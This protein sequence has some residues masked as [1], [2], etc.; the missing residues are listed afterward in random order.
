MVPDKK[1]TLLIK[2]VRKDTG[3]A[4]K[5]NKIKKKKKK[6]PRKPLDFTLEWVFLFCLWFIFFDG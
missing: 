3:K 4:I 6:Q 5:I 1:D 2:T